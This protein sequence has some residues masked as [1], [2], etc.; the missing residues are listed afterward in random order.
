MG[1]HSKR[2]FP[3]RCSQNQRLGWAQ[4]LPWPFFIWFLQNTTHLVTCAANKRHHYH[5]GCNI[6]M[7]S[8]MQQHKSQ[9]HQLCKCWN[10][11]QA[12]L[13]KSILPHSTRAS[14]KHKNV[15]SA[16]HKLLQLACEAFVKK[17]RNYRNKAK[18][19]FQVRMM[20][21]F[22]GTVWKSSFRV[23]QL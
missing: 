5:R 12:V 20:P 4:Q 14:S 21:H 22:S 16:G 18:P 15:G 7:L 3:L 23:K 6:S 10:K 9:S 2:S 8:K 17:E 11:P 1:F 19:W 13:W